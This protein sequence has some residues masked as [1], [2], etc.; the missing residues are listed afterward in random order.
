MEWYVSIWNSETKRIV[1]RGGEAHD[2]E[3]AIEQLVAMGRSL[4]HTEDGT[5]IGKFGNVVVDDEPGNSVP[6]GDQDLS[7][8]EL[9]RRVHAAI[10]YTMGRIEPSY[11]PIQTMPSGQ[12]GPT[13]FSTPTGAVTDQWDRIALWLSTYLDTAPVI[14]AEQTAI[15]DAIARTGVSW[16]EELQALFRSVNGFPHDA[17][18]PL[19]PS[20]ELFDLERVIDE[21]QVELEVWGEFAEDMDEDE[22]ST[23]MAGDS[24]GTWLPEFVPFAGVDGN[25]LFVDTRPGPLRGCVT[26]FDK[27]G[28]DDGGPQWISISALLTD[29]ADALESGRP[30]AGAWTPSVVDGQLKW[31]YTN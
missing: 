7:D 5:L 28:A 30:F 24:A 15:D 3:T 22:L 21:R 14:S 29:L 12:E 4:T 31:L 16:P 17:W 9:R 18:V 19:L 25:L 27:V 6:F 10:E 26:E 8:D 23:S 20:H 2:R 1:T 11:Q 13:K